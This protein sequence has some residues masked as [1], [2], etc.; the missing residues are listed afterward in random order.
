MPIRI[1]ADGIVSRS[2]RDTAA[3]L[4]ESERIYRNV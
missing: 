2:V 4:R 3:F 1:V